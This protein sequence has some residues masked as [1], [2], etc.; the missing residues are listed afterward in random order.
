MRI[1]TLLF[2]IGLTS[3]S[4][5][6]QSPAVDAPLS[7][8][9]GI[10]LKSAAM[11]FGGYNSIGLLPVTVEYDRKFSRRASWVAGAS[12]AW[13]PG[14]YIN[15]D[16]GPEG[17]CYDNTV[18]NATFTLSGKAA[19]DLPVAR[20][21]LMLRFEAGVAAT[22]FRVLREDREDMSDRFLPSLVAEIHW[23]LKLSKHL[24][25]LFSPLVV[26]PSFFRFSPWGAG[27]RTD[28]PYFEYNL[29]AFGI[30]TRF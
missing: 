3:F 24:R 26:S 29:G 27:G 22:Y 13:M 7:P 2:I 23:S 30:S 18:R 25:L 20:D 4:L 9:N 11:V 10:T 14:N 19:Y 5:H 8:R 16:C 17:G 1:F 6:A 12:F 28:K 21:I 15:Y